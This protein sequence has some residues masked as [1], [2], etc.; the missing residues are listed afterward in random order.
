MDIAI[1]AIDLLYSQGRDSHRRGERV[2]LLLYKGEGSEMLTLLQHNNAPQILNTERNFNHTTKDISEAQ[3]I[4]CLSVQCESRNTL[5]L[6]L[7]NHPRC[8]H[9]VA[10]PSCCSSADQ[11]SLVGSS[12]V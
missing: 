7:S 10:I 12:T 6:R 8:S 2:T 9:V 3:R 4:Q 5:T 1:E 11:G